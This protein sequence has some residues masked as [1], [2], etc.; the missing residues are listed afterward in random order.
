V[1]SSLTYNSK[2]RWLSYWYHIHETVSRKPE[3]ILIIGKGSGVVEK[4]IS[5]ISPIVFYG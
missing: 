3:N 2:G 5:V 4:T 1:Y